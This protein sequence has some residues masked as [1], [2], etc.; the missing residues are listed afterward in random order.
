[1]C[2]KITSILAACYH[3]PLGDVKEPS[4]TVR[5]PSA[6][7]HFYL[8][9]YPTVLL[10][11]HSLQRFIA[12]RTPASSYRNVDARR[13]RRRP[14]QLR[15]RPMP[16]TMTLISPRILVSRNSQMHRS[17]RTGRALCPRG[18]DYSKCICRMRL[19]GMWPFTLIEPIIAS[20][21]SKNFRDPPL[22][23]GAVH[24]SI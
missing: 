13:S 16:V 8:T 17:V 21:I 14:P 4:A 24:L 22:C 5:F 19:N 20:I 23:A 11:Q 6:A 12:S 1:M 9:D 10:P 18:G 15:G 3:P 2:P 7:G